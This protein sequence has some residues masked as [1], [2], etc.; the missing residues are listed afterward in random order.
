MQV[1]SQLS[2]HR[3]PMVGNICGDVDGG[4]GGGTGVVAVDVPTDDDEPPASMLF[5]F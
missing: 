4:G 2:S 1:Y 3:R 5:L